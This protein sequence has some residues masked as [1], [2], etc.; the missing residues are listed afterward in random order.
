M[1]NLAR[2]T[3][4]PSA[5]WAVILPAWTTRPSQIRTRRTR[6][7]PKTIS[8]PPSFSSLLSQLYLAL[9]IGIS[10][11]STHMLPVGR[12]PAHKITSEYSYQP[13]PPLPI[14]RPH[15]RP[16]AASRSG[17]GI[18]RGT[19]AD[20]S[21]KYMEDRRGLGPHG[22]GQV[23]SLGQMAVALQMTIVR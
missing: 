21:P 12:M 19:V 10:D 15:L 20:D 2:D 17:F 5:S 13:R 22:L 6:K 14:S 7:G 11:F 23:L 9:P 4:L 3:L 8:I 18:I 1:H 16:K